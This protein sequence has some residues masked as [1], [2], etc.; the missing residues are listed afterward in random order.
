MKREFQF[1]ITIAIPLIFVAA[2]ILWLP[3]RYVFEFNADEGINLIKAMMTLKGFELYSEVWSDQP[4]VLTAILA[5]VFR[6]LGLKVNAGRLLI[7][8]FSTALIG[9]A[10]DYLVRRWGVLHAIFGVIALVTL[11]FYTMLSV[12]I[13]IGL[14]SLAMAMLSFVSLDRWHQ[15]RRPG[16]LVASGVL[17]ALSL[18]TKIWTVVL[19]PVFLAGILL[20]EQKRGGHE[21]KIADR[22]RP[23]F[24]WAVGLIPV[25]LFVI[26]VMIGPTHL[27]QL[28]GVHLTAGE[29]AEMQAIAER[30]TVNSFLEDS[31]VLIGLS[32]FGIGIAVWKK[33]WH[34][35]YLVG[36]ALAGY[37]L[38][39]WVVVPTWFHHQL[40]VTIP[41]ALLGAIAMGTAAA[42]IFNRLRA[43]K[44]WAWGTLPSVL[45]LVVVVFFAL[46]RVPPTADNFRLDL[47]NFAAYDLSQD[48]D[49]EIVAIIG[50][51]AERT[52]FLFTDRPMYAFRSG[53]PVS[54]GLAVITQKRYST[55]DPTQEQIYSILL[56]TKPEQVI[57]TRFDHPAVQ[58]YMQPRNFIR[59]DKSPVSRHY[60]MREIMDAP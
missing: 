50:N 8:G 38:L 57:L 12:S 54:P 32:L 42:D 34:A 46:E 19:G 2:V 6:I 60:V 7:L 17:L 35:L 9:G 40:L 48:V 25:S 47:P 29:T 44:L 13:M 31:L 52:H 55:G 21:L 11:P 22:L 43:S 27:L 33:A 39:A 20:G 28:V 3:F 15:S 30:H 14:P 56:E 36:W 51:Y 41:V 58:R 37:S 26:F 24:W 16:W 1:L 4:P 10:T 5:F 49:F 18:F 45:I 53:V 23:V 59:V